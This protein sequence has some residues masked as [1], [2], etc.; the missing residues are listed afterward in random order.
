MECPNCKLENP[1]GA[2]RCD[3]GYD[4]ATR[5]VAV[6]IPTVPRRPAAPAIHAAPVLATVF[7]VLGTLEIIGGLIMC[8]SLWPGEAGSGYE[9]R[10][11]AYMPALVWLSAGIIFGCLFFAVAEGL[12]YLSEIRDAVS[13]LTNR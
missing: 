5:Q 2:I 7:R 1:P 10:T 9:W 3:C 11:T 13:D 4:F 12:T 6:R 8:F